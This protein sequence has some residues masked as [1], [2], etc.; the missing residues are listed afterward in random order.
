MSE[1]KPARAVLH[2]GLVLT[3]L[4]ALS[5]CTG[6]EEQRSIHRTAGW[7]FYNAANY[8]KARL[9]FANALK[10]EPKD[11]DARFGAGQVAESLQDYR[12]ALGH[13]QAA[14]DAEPKNVRANVA[15]G[16][17]LFFAGAL[18]EAA[19]R[20]DVVLAVQPREAE[21]MA[22]RA[23]ILL[24]RGDAAAARKGVDAALAVDPTNTYALSLSSSLLV[25][26]GKIDTAIAQLKDA[27]SAKPDDLALRRVYAELLLQQRRPEEAVAQL[28]QIIRLQPD[29]REHRTQLVELFVRLGDVKRAEATLRDAIA[30]RP[31]DSEL[32]LALVDFLRAD[33]R[34]DAAQQTLKS[35][36]AADGDDLTLQTA[37]GRLLSGLGKHAEAEQV[38]KG[39]IDTSG[40][41]VQ[42]MLARVE[43]A[44]GKIA[45]KQLAPAKVLID[46]VLAENALDAGALTLRAAL[47]MEAKKYDDAV[48]DLR[49][50][51][52]DAPDNVEMLNL[53][54]RAYLANGDRDLALQTLEALIQRNPP[55]VDSYL[56][57]AEMHVAN[58]KP[59]D[60][61]PVLDM[62]QRLAPGDARLATVRVQALIGSRNWKAA[63]SGAQQLIKYPASAAAGQYLLGLIAESQGNA[64]AAEA[65]YSASLAV[66]PKGTE[67][68]SKL[69]SLLMVQKRVGEARALVTATLAKTPKHPVA[70]Q[71]QGEL[72]LQAREY[73]LA[74][75]SFEGA[76][77][78]QAGWWLPYRGMALIA[79]AQN[80]TA[81]AVAAYR[82]G[83][84][85]TAG[86][87]LVLDLAA[88]TLSL[89]QPDVALG[90][91]RQA[92]QRDPGSE[93][94]T[95]NLAMLLVSGAAPAQA[96][97][98]EALQLAGKLEKSRQPAYMDTIGWV[99]FRRGAHAL[100][101]PYLARAADLQP[102]DPG[103]RFHLAAA[104]RALKQT[105]AARRNVALALKVPSFAERSEAEA[106]KQ[107]LDAG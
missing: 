41:G 35:Y 55:G 103:I 2:L 30:A 59:A 34:S 50:A 106:L 14:I 49:S 83:I 65:A 79:R 26:E 92:L 20:I 98:D 72:Q 95:N 78:A 17:L 76:A 44:R 22:V 89:K 18:S 36:I 64:R 39:V 10:I 51:L 60:A 88:L 99:H 52:R 40:E 13:Y 27:T 28:Q 46:E 56:L 62:A 54:A 74:L 6:P 32:K 53:L 47:A 97:L 70:L 90:L 71:F 101:L 31:T 5:G 105:D 42:G 21:A 12:A 38:L 58:G 66:D 68:L 75:L 24:A 37:L 61:V 80:D 86:P 69:M 81:G 100:A 15:M 94:A 82:R 93:E 23:A 45:T 9:E 8:E 102:E 33:N 57:L 11:A 43:L 84:A 67:P 48:A 1:V 3:A 73:A 85:A 25:R 7:T 19:K 63:E 29:V 16:R 87:Q 91:Y 77:Q 96:A 4:I 107:S 104:Q